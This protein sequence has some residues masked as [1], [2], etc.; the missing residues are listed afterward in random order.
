MVT[1]AKDGAESLRAE[2]KNSVVAAA[3][4]IAVVAD[5]GMVVALGREPGVEQERSRGG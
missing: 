3:A 4:V 1:G 2:E 5:M